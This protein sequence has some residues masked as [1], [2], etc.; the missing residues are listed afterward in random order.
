MN[1]PAAKPLVRTAPEIASTSASFPRHDHAGTGSFGASA[2][3]NIP[4]AALRP[5]RFL[6]R[7]RAPRTVTI[8]SRPRAPEMKRGTEVPLFASTPAW[9]R[10]CVVGAV[11]DLSLQEERD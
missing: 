8:G 9:R 6:R 4:K 11:L 10:R 3:G 2:A 7:S 5:K 1:R